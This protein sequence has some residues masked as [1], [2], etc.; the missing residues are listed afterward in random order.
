M[1]QIDMPMPRRCRTCPFGE[2]VPAQFIEWDGE[3]QLNCLIR[4]D[5]FVGYSAFKRPKEC[6]LKKVEREE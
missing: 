4:R 3:M 5:I 2:G 6:P 1:I